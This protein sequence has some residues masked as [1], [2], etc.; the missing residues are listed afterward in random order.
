MPYR[1]VFLAACLCLFGLGFSRPS[2]AAEPI[3]R[4]IST[5]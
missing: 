4:P 2:I 1:F 3:D 5:K